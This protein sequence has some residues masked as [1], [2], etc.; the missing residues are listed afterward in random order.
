MDPINQLVIADT[1]NNAIRV[2][3]GTRVVTLAGQKTPGYRDGNATTALFDSPNGICIYN[4][5]VFVSDRG[6]CR[7]RKLEFSTVKQMYEVSTVAG[8]FN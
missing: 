6:N 2:I 7:I 3:S 8:K 5:V 1:G 4:N